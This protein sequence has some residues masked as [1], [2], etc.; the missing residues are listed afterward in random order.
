MR[1][2]LYAAAGK[3]SITSD[4]PPEEDYVFAKRRSDLVKEFRNREFL[5][6]SCVIVE[7]LNRLFP[8]K[9]FEALY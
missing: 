2:K 5:Y 1:V 9:L 6:F 8:S 4:E 7:V 3:T